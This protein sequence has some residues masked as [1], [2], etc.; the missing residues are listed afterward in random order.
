MHRQVTLRA[1]A[2]TF[3]AR[4]GSA[5]TYPSRHRD[6]GV[7][8]VNII[9]R[10]YQLAA[11]S[12]SVEEV[13]RKLMREGYLNVHSHLSGHQIRHDLLKRLNPELVTYRKAQSA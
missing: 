7:N 8:G 3:S 5:V 9:E 6:Q 11:E 2:E 10:A 1:G 12:G 13:K 4:A